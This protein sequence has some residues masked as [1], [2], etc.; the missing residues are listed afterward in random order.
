MKG[1]C[2]VALAAWLL[3]ALPAWTQ[4]AQSRPAAARQEGPP[5][6]RPATSQEA[7][8]NLKKASLWAEQAKAFAPALHLVETPQFLIHS[9]W[10]RSDDKPL[11]EVCQKMYQAMCRQFDIPADQ[12]IWAGKCALYLF[13]QQE[14]YKRFS[15]EVC[16]YGSPDAGG[17]CG[18]E[19]NFVFLA[20][21]PCRNR[22]GFYELLVHEASHAFLLRYLTDRAL[23]PWLNEGLAEYMA[24][25][26][27]PG[28]GAGGK[29]VRA[30]AEAV[31]K[32]RDASGVLNRVGLV[33]FD[34][35]IAQSLVRFL[36]ARDRAAFVRLVALLKEGADEQQALRQSYDLT[37]DQF[38]SEW[39]KAA[40]N[41]LR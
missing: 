1:R 7:Q 5:K 33:D 11:A 6:Y 23:P 21:G 32:N 17:Y 20:I 31:R 38:L 26:L 18:Y 3:G 39:R 8:A 34:Y 30:T 10:N 15:T 40:A 16:K 9:T 37:R 2:T 14:E 13:R 4:P 22:N 29:Y 35:G 12:N 28:A 36:I 19:G 27:V 24:A 25:T 41:A